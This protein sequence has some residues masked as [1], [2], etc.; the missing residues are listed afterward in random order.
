MRTLNR[1]VESSAPW[2]LA[3]DAARSEELDRVL[4]ELADGLR[5]VAVLLAA[6]VPETSDGILFALR[7]PRELAWD[8]AAAGRAV[9][10][11][12]IEPAQPLFPRVDAPTAAA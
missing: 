7:Q 11:D 3:K 1:H 8:G 10:A 2:E 5:A 12:G 6:Y 9:A 4:Y